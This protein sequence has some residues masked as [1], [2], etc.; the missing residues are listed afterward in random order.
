MV[1]LVKFGVECE[2]QCADGMKI[3]LPDDLDGTANL[4]LTVADPG[5]PPARD[6][7]RAGQAPRHSTAGLSKLWWWRLSPEGLPGP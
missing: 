3:S 7:C 1:R 5:K 4:R 6:P 2:E